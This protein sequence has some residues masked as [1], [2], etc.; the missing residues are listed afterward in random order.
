LVGWLLVW[1][2]GC[3]FGCSWLVD[4]LVGCLLGFLFSCLLYLYLRSLRLLISRNS[5]CGSVYFE[6]CR[7]SM[8]EFFCPVCM[9]ALVLL[10][11]CSCILFVL[12]SQ[13]HVHFLSLFFSFDCLFQPVRVCTCCVVCASVR[14]CSFV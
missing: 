8:L 13:L 2:V 11:R 1:L 6:Y 5:A 12:L 14:Q 3:L 4:W 9:R 10:L 7:A